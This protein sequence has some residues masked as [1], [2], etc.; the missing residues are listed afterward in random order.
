MNA[1]RCCVGALLLFLAACAAPS[2]P[3]AETAQTQVVAGIT[4]ALRA[5]S[6]PALNQAETFL[7]D[8]TDANGAP[9]TDALVSLNLDMPAMP[10]S[11]NRPIAEHLGNGRYQA[12]TAYT[13]SGSWEI[14]VQVEAAG[15]TLNAT[16]TREVR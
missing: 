14:I 2:Q 7:I 3:T 15:Q 4:I 6:Q 11:S 13:M 5:N 8:L 10:M 1:L 12:Q 16:F 9:I